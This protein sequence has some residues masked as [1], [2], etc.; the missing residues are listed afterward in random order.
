MIRIGL[1]AEQKHR[2]IQRYVAEHNVKSVI[3]FSPKKF[4]LQLP[5]LDVPIREVEYAEVIMYR[6]FYPLL[7]EIGADH[8][9][10][11]NEFLRDKNR[12]N[13]TFNC[14]RHYLNQCGHQIILEYFPFID[15]E[16]DFMALLDFDTKSKRKGLGFFDGYLNDADIQCVNHNITLSV[17]TVCANPGEYEFE[18]NRLFDELGNK[19]PDTIP[20]NLELFVGKWKKSAII[21]DGLYA[22]RNARFGMKNVINMAKV[23]YGKQYTL[24][25]MPHRQIDMNDFLKQTGMSSVKFVSTGLPVDEMYITQ[26][27]EWL[28]RLEEFYAKTSIYIADC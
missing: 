27:R 9:L 19:D 22:A 15:D 14:L 25:D 11:V 3:V 12:N 18:K 1:T 2:E 10:V 16:A 26:F 21:P 20:R 6:T 17:Q 4:S 24:L 23:E 28:E 7:E 13:L 8:L 5:A